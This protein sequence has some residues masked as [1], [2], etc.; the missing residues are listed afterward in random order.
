MS[1][2]KKLKKPYAL[3]IASCLVGVTILA[4]AGSAATAQG[5]KKSV[6]DGAYSKAQAQRGGSAFEKQCRACHGDPMFGPS[7]I[8]AWEGLPVAE[9]FEFL[10]TSM[11]EDNPGS[12]QHAQY[13][14]ILAYFFSL[15]GLPPGEAELV[16]DLEALRQIQIEKPLESNER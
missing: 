16:P 2:L 13:V 8:D 15:R 4:A 1:P 11:P 6:R 3:C 7:V 10:S 12:L 5:S 14:D 9:L